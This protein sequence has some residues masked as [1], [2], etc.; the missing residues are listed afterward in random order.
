[1]VP[2]AGRGISPSDDKVKKGLEAEIGR[3]LRE[4]GLTLA[5]AESCTGG[6]IGDMI[7]DVA[8]SSDYFTGGIVAYSNDVKQGIL[9]VPSRI[10]ERYGAV[11]KQTASRMAEGVKRR[12]KTDIG[13]ATTGIAGPTGGSPRKPVG[14]VFIALSCGRRVYTGRFLFHGTRRSIK[15]QTALEALRALKGFLERGKNPFK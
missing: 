3:L 10:L 11:S 9:G 4:R 6:L 12:L 7:T 1:M 8:G 14:T 15:R 13:I 5:V 2:S